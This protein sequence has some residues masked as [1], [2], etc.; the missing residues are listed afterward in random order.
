MTGWGAMKVKN[1]TRGRLAVVVVAALAL[2]CAALP[3]TASASTWT[4]RQLSG[5]AA[6]AMLFGMSCPTTSFCATV[7]GN[8]T[9][10]T[11]T[12][13]SGDANSWSTSYL[14]AGPIVIEGGGI[15][16]GRQ[17][18]GVDCPSPA[19]CVAVSLEGLIY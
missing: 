5:E 14:G 11:S 8:N 17:V 9:V 4:G 16:N 13:P 7:G 6:K 1:G 18:R 3:A 10:A 12:D 15:F 2:A 19:L